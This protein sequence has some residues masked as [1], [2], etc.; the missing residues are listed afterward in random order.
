MAIAEAKRS[1]RSDPLVMVA[2]ENELKEDVVEV[3]KV[4][5]LGAGG[6]VKSTLSI[7]SPPATDCGGFTTLT[8][9]Q[10]NR[11]ANVVVDKAFRFIWI[12]ATNLLAGR[13]DN[14]AARS[15][16]ALH[17][18]FSRTSRATLATSCAC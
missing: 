1:P 2:F 6:S 7:C 15:W 10:D 17:A 3:V 5:G 18:S 9:N 16:G 13:R 12:S 14:A 4:E 8:T 11:S